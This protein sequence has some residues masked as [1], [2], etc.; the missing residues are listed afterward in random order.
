I[1]WTAAIDERNHERC[2]TPTDTTNVHVHN[3]TFP[4]I[5]GR[6]FF[7]KK[8]QAGTGHGSMHATVHRSKSAVIRAGIRLFRVVSFFLMPP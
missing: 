5:P 1:R 7:V 2:R 4:E 8:Q 6:P 3:G